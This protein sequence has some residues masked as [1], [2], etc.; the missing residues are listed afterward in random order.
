MRSKYTISQFADIAEAYPVIF[1]DSYGVLRNHRGLIP[2]AVETMDRLRKSGKH[3]R[4]LTNNAARSPAMAAERLAYYGMKDI[5]A[6]EIIT[7][8]ATT[9]HFLEQK[10]K[11]GKVAYLGTATSAEYII[12]AGLEA[13]PISEV[14]FERLDEIGAVAF[15]DDEGYD[16]NVDINLL[17]NILRRCQVPVVVANTDLLYPTTANDVALATGSVARL[18][19]YVLGRKFVKF[20][21]PATQMFQMGL[22]SVALDM[23]E[24]CPGDI[25]MVGDTLHTDILGGN[26]YGMA[27]ALVL[28]GNT[29]PESAELEIEAS[30]IIPDYVCPSIGQ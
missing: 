2:G 27:T 5:P 9:R 26:T 15:L 19:E 7:S 16:M 17:I 23:P 12:G 28:S 30:G 10:V 4:V 18:A 22:D 11:H 1:F 3:I 24:V 14:D 29:R 25:L 13:I 6:S 21:K 20:G 8:G